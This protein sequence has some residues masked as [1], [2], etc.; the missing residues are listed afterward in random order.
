MS[1]LVDIQEPGD[2][3]WTMN[4]GTLRAWRVMDDGTLVEQ[5]AAMVIV[6]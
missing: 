5:D 3:V 2:I 1:Q 4:R 6:R